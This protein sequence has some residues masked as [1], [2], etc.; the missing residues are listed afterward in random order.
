MGDDK[1]GPAKPADQADCETKTEESGAYLRLSDQALANELSAEFEVDEDLRSVLD[2]LPYPL[3]LVDEEH[4]I[5]LTNRAAANF[6]GKT[7]RELEG[8]YCP[9]SI[10]GSDAPVDY[11]P[12][13]QSVATD[14]ACEKTV[15]LEEHTVWVETGTYPTAYESESGK[16]VYVHTVK[17]ISERERSKH[18]LEQQS[19]VRAALYDLMRLSLREGS[20][21]EALE[22]FLDRLF[23]IPWLALEH[24]GAIFLADG[25]DRLKLSAQRNLATPLLETCKFVVPG[26]CMC[27][28]ALE[29]GNTVFASSMDERHDV[30]FDGMADH[31]HYCV[32]MTSKEKVIG[33]LNLYVPVGHEYSAEEDDFLKSV[34]D[35]L[36]GFTARVTATAEREQALAEVQQTL[37]AT[38]TAIGR[39]LEARDPYT[40]GR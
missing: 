40:A 6:T 5:V 19:R 24:K 1:S 32:P 16:R 31:G 37:W 33:V 36:A 11:C 23:A 30:R 35:L 12:L 21:Q 2:S 17:D 10:H 29:S 25:P 8:T 14:A 9:R 38:V 39:M 15:F 3:M 27:G 4:N 20:Q 18:D 7:A 28:R 34:A 26:R 22:A 13:E